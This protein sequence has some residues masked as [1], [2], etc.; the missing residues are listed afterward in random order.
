MTLK[1]LGSAPKYQ[2]IDLSSSE[3]QQELPSFA[4]VRLSGTS[5]LVCRCALFRPKLC[6]EGTE[7]AARR[8]SL[9]F[10]VQSKVARQALTMSVMSHAISRTLCR[11]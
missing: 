5:T 4:A 10:V 6:R 2:W 3:V 1:R 8:Y 9:W 11:R 7:K